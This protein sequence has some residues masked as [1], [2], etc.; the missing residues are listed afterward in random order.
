[1]EKREKVMRPGSSTN[2][3]TARL[4]QQPSVWQRLRLVAVIAV[5]FLAT[6]S[7][8]GQTKTPATSARKATPSKSPA[9]GEKKSAQ[10]ADEPDFRWLQDLLKDKEL[11]AEI[12]KLGEKLRDGVQYPATRSQSNILPRLPETTLF[13][14]AFPN[15]GETMH[16][17][18][19][20]FQQELR[21]STPLRDFLH[22]NKLDA[23]EPKIEDGLEKFYL[24]SQFLGDEIVLTGKMQG[25]EPSFLVIA[26]VKKPGLK[27]FLEKLNN[28][29]ITNKN[30]RLRIIDPQELAAGNLGAGKD[31]VVVVRPD[32]VVMG[33]G[34]AALREMNAQLD[35]SGPRFTSNP[36]G[37][38]VAQSYQGGTNSV[39]GI[40]LHKVIGLIPQTKPQDREYLQKSGFADVKYLVTENRMSAGRSANQMELAFN[41]PRHGIASWIAAPARMGGLDF[42]SSQAAMAG[43]IMLKS[44]AQILDDVVE[45]AG[46]QALAALPQMEAQFNVNLKQDLLSKLGGEIAFEL[47]MPPMPPVGEAAA[48][49][50]KPQGPG[51]F[52]VI[53][54]VSDPAG[55]QQTLTRLLKDGPLQSGTREEDGVTFHT[56]TSP[57]ASGPPTEF[58]Y[59]FMDGYLVIASDAVTATEAVRA[60]R[61]GDSLGK[62]SKLR[63]SLANGQS[64]NAS[65]M[66]YQNAGQMLGPM[67]AQLPAEMRELLP[68]T[69]AVDTKPNVYYVYANESSFRGTTSNNVNTDVSMALI[70]AAIAVPNLLRSRMAANEAAAASTVRTVN[71][72]Q[73]T[74]SVAY[75]KKGYAPNLAALGPPANGDCSEASVAPAHACL[76]DDVL[77][78]TSCTAGK[79]CTKGAYRYS[80]KGTCTQTNC[81]SYVVTA[82]PVSADSGGKSFCSTVDAVVRVHTG[83]PL[84]LPLTAAQCRAWSPIY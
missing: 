60:H 16:Q 45:I 81:G 18:L 75:P 10:K 12:T 70:V 68:A 4:K 64:A 8:Q 55:L 44:P 42:I 82:T 40:D 22:K 37:Q 23:V 51:A 9:S 29:L 54:R 53:F 7:L 57:G 43:D 61:T 58:N 49:R 52:K 77:G 20:I 34:T 25:Q 80:I 79:W 46:S 83:T 39:I 47:Q 17:A 74:Y 71:T 26:E 14:V 33:F 67:L 11:M 72:A 59:F 5:I 15:Y 76:L 36:L 21:E 84:E 2:L 69:G 3:Q 78:N 48:N 38:R 56:L 27:E 50:A 30:D 35:S 32:L 28:E 62:S 19:Q 24:F 41:G 73:V 1:M 31:P 65:M 63:E 66:F 6:A 13:Y